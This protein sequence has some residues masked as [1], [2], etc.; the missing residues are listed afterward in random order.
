MQMGALLTLLFPKGEWNLCCKNGLLYS[1]CHFFSR[2]GRN[3]KKFVPR[4]PIEAFAYIP[5]PLLGRKHSTTSAA[6]STFSPSFL[7]VQSHKA[8]KATTAK[9]G[10]RKEKDSNGRNGRRKEKMG[11]R[12]ELSATPPSPPHLFSLLR[13]GQEILFFPPPRFP[14]PTGEESKI[15]MARCSPGVRKYKSATPRLGNGRKERKS[16]GERVSP[17]P[18]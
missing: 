14:L 7:S 3:K 16:N 15:L 1:V 4:L 10:G 6:A 8:T 13:I 2:K 11:A 18:L 12:D 17:L 9:G 5:L